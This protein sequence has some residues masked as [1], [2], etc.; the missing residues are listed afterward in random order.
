MDEKF[1]L[2]AYREAEK[3]YAQG[4]VPIGAVVVRQGQVI[5]RGFNKKE[6]SKNPLFHGEMEAIYR[7]AQVLGR[8]RLSDCSLYVTLE[9]CSMCAG[10]IVN[11]RLARLVYAAPDKKR[12][13]CGS[14][15]DILSHPSSN[16]YPEV[17]AG[18]MASQCSQLL[19]DFFQELRSG[20][21]KY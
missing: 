12:G 4:E 9:P 8:W 17:V 19:S 6:G 2:E 5:A 13:C 7:A 15:L 14:S 20:R 11:A 16:Y 10:A 1:M 3:A 21:V 18:V